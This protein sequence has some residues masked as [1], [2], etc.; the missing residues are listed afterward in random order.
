[1]NYQ[2]MTTDALSELFDRAVAEGWVLDMLLDIEE[3]LY[4]REAVA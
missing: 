1:M 2:M 4:R 3:E